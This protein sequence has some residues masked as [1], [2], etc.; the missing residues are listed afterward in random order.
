VPTYPYLHRKH[1]DLAP[2]LAAVLKQMKSE[3]LIKAY[4]LQVERDLGWRN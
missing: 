2:R 3:G 4:R 1:A